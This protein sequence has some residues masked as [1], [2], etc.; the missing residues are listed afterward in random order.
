M[1]KIVQPEFDR[2]FKALK[3]LYLNN[4][5]EIVNI[6]LFLCFNP[7]GSL[8]WHGQSGQ[9]FEE[10]PLK[11]KSKPLGIWRRFYFQLWIVNEIQKSEKPF[12]TTHCWA[13]TTKVFIHNVFHS[14][15]TESKMVFGWNHTYSCERFILNMNCKHSLIRS[16][17]FSVNTKTQNASAFHN[18]A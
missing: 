7:C 4:K 8:Q 17:Q 15:F 2:T 11:P 16:V 10:L 18:Q 1:L 14:L 9:T 5:N 6:K 12:E 3:F 13:R